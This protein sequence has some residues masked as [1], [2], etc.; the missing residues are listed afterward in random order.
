MEIGL[1]YEIRNKE[2]KK[3]K[4]SLALINVKYNSKSEVFKNKYKI[5]YMLAR[6]LSKNSFFIYSMHTLTI[7]EI[8]F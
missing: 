2:N 4:D 1:F 5:K 7:T 3:L 8:R 6:Y